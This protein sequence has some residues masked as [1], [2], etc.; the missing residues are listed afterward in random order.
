MIGFYKEV[1]WE[2]KKEKEDVIIGRLRQTLIIA[3]FNGC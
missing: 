2:V 3:S 1:A